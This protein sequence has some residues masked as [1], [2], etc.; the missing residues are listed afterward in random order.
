MKKNGRMILILV[1]I[2]SSLCACAMKK[3]TIA[4][5]LCDYKQ[6]EVPAEETEIS[7]EDILFAAEMQMNQMQIHIPKKTNANV[8]EEGDIISIQA[9]LDEKSDIICISV[10]KEEFDEGFDDFVVGKQLNTQY[11]FKQYIITILDIAQSAREVTD[12]IAV[13]YFGFRNAEDYLSS[14][15]QDIYDHRVFEYRYQYFIE[16]SYLSGDSGERHD[17]INSHLN[18]NDWTEYYSRD[19]YE[20][21]LS[22]FYDEY[23]LLEALVKQEKMMFPHN[24]LEQEWEKLDSGIAFEEIQACREEDIRYQIY[25]ALCYKIL[26]SY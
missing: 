6:I 11:F 13:Q 1:L 22:L 17:Y 12:E 3:N 16:H 18:E 20:K 21:R 26:L 5:Q 19:E 23:L 8:V 4:V 7:E 9:E 15:K 24:K 14:V 2:C 10:G 25:Q